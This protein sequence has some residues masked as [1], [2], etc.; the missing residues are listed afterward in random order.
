M[1]RG[2]RGNLTFSLSTYIGHLLRVRTFEDFPEHIHGR[3]GLEGDT[4]PHVVLV[5]EADDF[6]GVSAVVGGVGGCGGHGGFV[7][8]GVEVA[9]GFLELG[10]PFFGLDREK[11]EGWVSDSG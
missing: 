3:F 5:N 10:D 2:K 9:A 8:E 7:V 6:F 1:E 4:R 11:G